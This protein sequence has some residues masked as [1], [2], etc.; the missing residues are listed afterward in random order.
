MSNPLS[1]S[2]VD[3]ELESAIPAEQP[4]SS[5]GISPL[6]LQ[7]GVQAAIEAAVATEVCSEALSAAGVF[8]MDFS[9]TI[10][11]SSPSNMRCLESPLLND[12]ASRDLPPIM[13]P[14]QNVFLKDGGVIG[15]VEG[16]KTRG[17]EWAS[18]SE[19]FQGMAVQQDLFP[20]QSL[21]P[22][23]VGLGSIVKEEMLFS[24]EEWGLTPNAN[25]APGTPPPFLTKT[26]DLVEDLSCDHIVSWGPANNS[27]IVWDPHA[28]S[29]DLLPRFFKHNNFSSFVRQLNTY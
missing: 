23:S 4:T 10:V 13:S 3:I 2:S 21:L 17:G 12:A 15:A 20:N 28:F 18:T 19:R 29:R 16:A 27:F 24:A 9:S 7:R 14:D 25:L 8:G 1:T 22:S 6:P 5:E 26:Y 11:S